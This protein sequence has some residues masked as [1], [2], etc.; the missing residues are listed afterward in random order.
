MTGPIISYA[1]TVCDELEEPQRLLA[2]LGKNLA[3]VDEIVIQYDPPKTPQAVLDYL[4]GL[5][6][7]VVPFAFDDDFAAFKNNLKCHCRGDYIFQ[8]DA[9][10]F[11]GETQ[12]ARLRALL[13][14]NPAVDVPHVPR[15]NTVT[16]LTPDHLRRWNWQLNELGWANFPDYQTR[17]WRNQNTIFWEN[18]VHER[19]WVPPSPP[20]FCLLRN[21][22]C[23]IPWT[24]PTKNGRIFI[25]GSC[26]MACDG[27]PPAALQCS[28][29][30]FSNIRY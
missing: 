5:S 29:S 2:I 20:G 10:E 30:H 19:L 27:A 28:I 13:E 24:S 6:A 16:G 1:I 18:Q 11:P 12:L 21:S 7:T 4:A 22:A 9:D 8:I 15:I 17:I 26:R 23:F 25:A 3:P 14:A